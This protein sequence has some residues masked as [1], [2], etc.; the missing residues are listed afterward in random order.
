MHFQNASSEHSSALHCAA[1]LFL[2]PFLLRARL[3]PWCG[4]TLLQTIPVIDRQMRGQPCAWPHDNHQDHD[5]QEEDDQEDDQD[6]D[7]DDDHCHHS[8]F[9]S[10]N[11]PLSSSNAVSLQLRGANTTDV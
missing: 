5:D 1:V 2:V 6:G 4:E 3:R 8:T 10:S 11:F 7:Q 9:V